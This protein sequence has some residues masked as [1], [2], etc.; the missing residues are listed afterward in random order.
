MFAVA[1]RG[2]RR[3]Q[4]GYGSPEGGD[5]FGVLV[6]FATKAVA[7]FV[8]LLVCPHSLGDFIAHSV[9]H[10]ANADAD[11]RVVVDCGSTSLLEHGEAT[12]EVDIAGLE[13]RQLDG[14]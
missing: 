1:I 5:Q 9:M 7:G 4:G 6:Q 10:P 8:E 3:L 2:P 14:V 13:G 11:V 12:N